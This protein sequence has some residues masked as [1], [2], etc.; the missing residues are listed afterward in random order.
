MLSGAEDDINLL[1][2]V[3][4]KSTAA[5]AGNNKEKQGMTKGGSQ[6]F[7]GEDIHN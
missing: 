1:A 3:Q 7:V 4:R 6:Y 5:V 2:Y